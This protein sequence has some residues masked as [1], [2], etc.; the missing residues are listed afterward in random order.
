MKVH[1]TNLSRRTPP[2]NTTIPK[3]IIQKPSAW[4]A[5]NPNFAVR[6]NNG[7]ELL[8]PCAV[9][10]LDPDS[11][12]ALFSYS[13]FPASVPRTWSERVYYYENQDD[14]NYGEIHSSFAR[15]LKAGYEESQ[16]AEDMLAILS[17]TKPD[18][19]YKPGELAFLTGTVALMFG[20]EASRFPS[21]L[22]INLLLLDLIQHG[23]RY[24]RTG[25]KGFSFTTAFH[26]VTGSGEALHWDNGKPSTRL[27][28]TVEHY[29]YGGKYPYAVHGTGS[30]NMSMREQMAQGTEGERYRLNFLTLPQRHAVPRREVAL[31]IHWVES[32]LSDE[33]LGD[34]T[35]RSLYD[36]L[37]ARLG[38]GYLES[39]DK[40]FDLR[41]NPRKGTGTHRP[42]VKDE[43]IN[44][45]VFWYSLGKYYHVNPSCKLL[46]GYDKS[47][48]DILFA[49]EYALPGWALETLEIPH[50]SNS[51]TQYI[52]I[53]SLS[54]ED[55]RSR[56]INHFGNS[57][58]NNL[59]QDW[60]HGKK[61]LKPNEKENLTKEV[62]KRVDGLSS[63]RIDTHVANLQ[64]AI[65]KLKSAGSLLIQRGVPVK[66]PFE[67]AELAEK[68]A[69]L[70]C[71]PQKHKELVGAYRKKLE[72]EV[73]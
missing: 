50:T 31:V 56:Y 53:K 16:L 22:L 10:L 46:P 25:T 12:D 49:S 48:N 15:L 39:T 55:L 23:K 11:H 8:L 71:V 72:K 69:C 21:A 63:D 47:K 5:L 19:E 35:Y 70:S 28:D 7:S 14:L 30:G 20:M 62:Q 60:Y 57:T 52:A 73:T 58:W 44:D 29:W 33:Q 4:P 38:V 37:F 1:D 59:R 42:E 43:D 9:S 3:L 67:T 2:G 6:G 65:D 32:N 61:T 66:G 17:G 27:T 26:R 40:V 24:G 64:R 45:E 34:L 18:T 41:E 68:T 54:T 13:N 51:L 36:L